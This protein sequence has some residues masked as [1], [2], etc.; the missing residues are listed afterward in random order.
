MH[1]TFH[2]ISAPG[3][4]I[5]Q[6]CTAI[7]YEFTNEFG[8]ISS[9]KYDLII[10]GLTR[11][12]IISDQFVQSAIYL[13][14]DVT[15]CVKQARQYPQWTNVL[16]II[17]DYHTWMVGAILFI[18]AIILLY[19]TTTFESRPMDAWESIT[20]SFQT[21][22]GVS[23]HS[24]KPKGIIMRILYIGAL[25]IQLLIV[26]IYSAYYFSFITRTIFE[27]QI[28][29]IQEII[30]SNYRIYGSRR[31]IEHLKEHNV[32]DR[33]PGF[34]VC[35]DFDMCL[36]QLQDQSKIAVAMS[37]LYFDTSSQSNIY[38][39]D[40]T[41]NLF[42]HSIVF[43]IR[44]ELPMHDKFINALNHLSMSG[45]IS[46]WTRDLHI[47]K[48]PIEHTTAAESLEMKNAV[49]PFAICCPTL[50]LAFV[51]YIAELLI[52]WR[53]SKNRES[54]FWV[55]ADKFIDGHR[56]YM[57]FDQYWKTKRMHDEH[58][59]NLSEVT[60]ATHQIYT[61]RIGRIQYEFVWQD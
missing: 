6:K 58:A 27:K 47:R 4:D 23:S 52:F 19:L 14:D 60:P 32:A 57:R 26:T 48:T 3:I 30:D 31:T 45:L 51:A 11:D 21:M 61:K 17:R 25:F 36:K 8:P 33:F 35:E 7:E 53:F 55:L 1:H 56:H 34:S 24:F 2:P 37:R 50:I 9:E 29:T 22:L 41:Q 13:Q 38:C 10:G 28:S 40:R 49:G 16:F 42:A 12:R 59:S 44:R 54:R 18:W 39:F 15:L 20:F 5:E 46:K 43:M